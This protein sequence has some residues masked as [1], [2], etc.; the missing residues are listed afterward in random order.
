[1]DERTDLPQFAPFHVGSD[2]A[3]AEPLSIDDRTV[4]TA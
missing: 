2:R 3:V 1:M 4:R